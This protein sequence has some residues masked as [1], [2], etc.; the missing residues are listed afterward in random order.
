MKRITKYL[1]SALSSFGFIFGLASCGGVSQSPEY[2]KVKKAFD[3]VE[4]SFKASQGGRNK[5]L[6]G[7]RS[8]NEGSSGALSSLEA[9]MEAKAENK[10]DTIDELRYDE[11]PMIQFQCLKTVYESI[12]GSFAFSTK[13]YDVIKG[14]AYFDLSNGEEKSKDDG[15]Q[16]HYSYDFNLGLGISFD[17]SLITAD[18]S[19]DITL[20]QGEKSY[21]VSWFVKMLLEYDFN[22]SSP[23]YALLMLTDN[24]QTD[25]P[26]RLGVTYEY[27]YVKVSQNKISEW[28]KFVYE[29]DQKLIKDEAHPSFDSYKDAVTYNSGHP[30]WYKNGNLR[31]LKDLSGG[32]DLEIAR[33]LYALG[34]NSSDIQKD[35]FFKGEGEKNGKIADIYRS[36]SNIFQKDVIY[37][38]ITRHDG[39]E[40]GDASPDYA[41]I[42]FFFAGSDTG[43]DNCHCS[44][45][46][47]AITFADLFSQDGHAWGESTYPAIWYMDQ[48]GGKVSEEK[49]LSKFKAIVN[50]QSKDTEVRFEDEVQ[51]LFEEAGLGEGTYTI[52]LNLILKSNERVSGS[53]RIHFD[54]VA[55]SSSK[56]EDKE[57]ASIALEKDNEIIEQ[58][59]F[60]LVDDI[61]IEDLFV[62][63]VTH[64]EY[65]EKT[66][67]IVDTIGSYNFIY[68][69]KDGKKLGY[70]PLKDIAFGSR[71]DSDQE[72]YFYMDQSLIHKRVSE[73]WYTVNSRYDADALNLVAEAKEIPEAKEG[74]RC[75]FNISVKRG[76]VEDIPLD[77]VLHNL[78]P[79][80]PI[81]A[82]GIAEDLPKV[83]PSQ[84]ISDDEPYKYSFYFDGSLTYM[85]LTVRLDNQELEAYRS[86]L[87][88]YSYLYNGIDPLN[89]EEYIKDQR[90][91]TI[92]KGS[93]EGT[94][95]IEV[96]IMRDKIVPQELELP[97]LTLDYLEQGY[98]IGTYPIRVQGLSDSDIKQGDIMVEYFLGS[99]HKGKVNQQT[100][101][102][103]GTYELTAQVR[104]PKPLDT[105]IVGSPRPSP[106]ILRR[107][108]PTLLARGR[109]ISNKSPFCKKT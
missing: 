95:T 6:Y 29:V 55:S 21:A 80:R 65:I 49:D 5:K 89:R 98:T 45:N 11:P 79:A 25:L 2:Q 56:E 24:T 72:G 32:T 27:D 23:T 103:P 39:K 104:Y 17:H 46:D 101:R 51:S 70:V 13:Y 33:D 71:D 37:S 109:P 3:G 28:R 94:Y 99:N 81:E 20:K 82:F 57:I 30:S 87:G 64:R 42:R 61:P 62:E 69:N 1:L 52:G 74:R 12:G 76:L 38:L 22:A 7:A 35:D 50:F 26:Y 96:R 86:L 90:C 31:K 92:A 107:S 78:W 19:F 40:G 105:W 54:Y 106:L 41:S 66:G 84:D 44:N 77:S 16:Y 73:L 53:M 34:L 85:T 10:G 63:G 36:F 15:E 67:D 4:S 97:S 75:R 88:S 108:A 58:G 18:V 9:L 93:S 43:F 102:N 100:L 83:S 48:Y 68:R 14:D 91:L 47:R 8:L 59:Y 60:S